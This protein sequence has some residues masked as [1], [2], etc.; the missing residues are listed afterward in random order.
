M[1]TQ[2]RYVLISPTRD[3]AA[4][5]A[6]TLESVVR[7]TVR[8]AR[9]II[10]D[11]GS[12]DQTPSLLQHYADRYDFIEL[13]RRADRG[14]R[15]V[16]P[17]VVD[18][19]NA[20]LSHVELTSFDYLGK[21]DLDLELPRAYFETLMQRFEADPSLGTC[22]GKPYYRVNGRLVSEGCGDEMSVGMTKF[23]RVACFQ[24][25]GGFAPQVMWDGLD[26]HMCRM[27]GWRAQSFD[28]T[29]ALRFVHRRPM[30]SSDKNV[31]RGRQRH[32]YGQYIMGTAPSYMLASVINRLRFRPR[33]IGALAMGW[34]YLRPW[35]RREP[36]RPPAHVQRFIRQYQRCCL[37]LGKA[38]AT[39]RFEQHGIF[40]GKGDSHAA[41]RSS[42]AGAGRR[43][44]R[45]ATVK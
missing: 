14:T 21:L 34:G 20:G 35:L 18:A 28:D 27:T 2:R 42:P 6:Y 1:T 11:D 37:L 33:V 3:E 25:I 32:G 41:G 36:S 13:H 30:G 29:P 44:D 40:R 43:V 31:L 38:R 22:S 9:W 39:A 10:V 5:A 7:Q 45:A 12:T 4:H 16:G 19:F 15:R 26:C 24:A 8:P 23:Y 17:G